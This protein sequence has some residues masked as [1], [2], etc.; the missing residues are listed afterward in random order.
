M[1]RTKMRK[2]MEAIADFLE[3]IGWDTQVL[4]ESVSIPTLTASLALDEDYD[5]LLVFNYIPMKKEDVEFTKLLQIYGRIPL[6]LHTLPL[7]DVHLLM[8]RMNLL[9]TFGYFVLM[10]EEEKEEGETYMGLRCVLGIPMEELPDE[11][12]IGETV[13]HITRYCQI[14]ESL[15]LGLLTGES[16]LAE[17]LASIESRL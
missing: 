6:D 4:I 8:N 13:L 11:G 10:P 9:T 5:E 1:T 14:M 16:T 3:D 15:L 17:T 12:V 7:E 2:D